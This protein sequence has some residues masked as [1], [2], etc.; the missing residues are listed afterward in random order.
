MDQ[1]ASARGRRGH[2]ILL[3]C[4][5]LDV[6]WVPI[7]DRA[8][9][10]ILDTST[11]RELQ[12]SAYNDR[13]RECEA[14]ARA[15][16]VR[17]LRDVS[18]TELRSRLGAL[19]EPLGRRARHVVTENARTLAAAETM[20]AGDV[21]WAG[22]LMNESHASLRDD[23]EVSSKALDAIVEAAQATDGCFGARLTGG[24]FA[25]CAIALVERSAAPAFE[26]AVSSAYA[27]STGAACAIFVCRASDGASVLPR[28]STEP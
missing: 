9:I 10:V 1:L 6:E 17:S 18:E 16:G 5:S 15:L 19:P 4:R 11:R 23:F 24:G 21:E 8:S 25:G 20:R 26:R 13:R 28:T 22:R 3:D 12:S 2:A 7:P 14:A 27:R